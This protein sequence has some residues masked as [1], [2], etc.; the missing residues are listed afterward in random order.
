MR[1][2]VVVYTRENGLRKPTMT[3]D[4]QGGANLIDRVFT[5]GRTVVEILDADEPTS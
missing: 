5:H 1:I 2:K 4:E 3:I